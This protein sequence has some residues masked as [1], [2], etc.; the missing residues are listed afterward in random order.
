MRGRRTL[1]VKVPSGVEDGMRIRLNG[2]GEVGP[3]GGPA[4][5]LYIEIHEREHPQFDREGDDLHCQ[6]NIPMTT[7][8]LGAT[9]DLDTLDSKEKITV[10]PGTQPGSPPSPS[11][12]AA[13]HTCGAGA[14]ATSSCMST[15]RSP[16]VSTPSR[17]SSS[18]TSPRFAVRSRS[19]DSVTETAPTALKARART[20]PTRRASASSASVGAAARGDR[21]GL[22]AASA[23][24]RAPGGCCGP[25][26]PRR[27]GGPACGDGPPAAR[28]R[29]GRR[30]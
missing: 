19:K 5:D 7:A 20:A 18:A 15:S 24:H 29:A 21:A 22:S 2:E 9:V 25:V 14:G 11:T 30:H 17:R 16:P 23:A 4:G 6:L 26:D 10:K 1:T 28:R 27:S 8:V 12:P 3:G 13:C